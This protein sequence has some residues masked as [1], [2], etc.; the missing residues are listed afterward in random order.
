MAEATQI[1]VSKVIGQDE[2]HSGAAGDGQ[3]EAQSQQQRAERRHRTNRKQQ[4]AE[5]KLHWSKRERER[6]VRG[7]VQGAHRGKKKAMLG[8]CHWD[9]TRD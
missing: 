9:K 2:H 1:S 8:E 6:G 4:T 7:A 3:A 5:M